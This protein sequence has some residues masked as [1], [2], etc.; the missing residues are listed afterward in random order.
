[1]VQLTTNDEDPI[2]TA[3]EAL[4]A[5]DVAAD[6]FPE[7]QRASAHVRCTVQALCRRAMLDAM[8]SDIRER[9]LV[10]E[11]RADLLDH[12]AHAARVAEQ[13]RRSSDAG[14]NTVNSATSYVNQLQ[15][16]IDQLCPCNTSVTADVRVAS[17]M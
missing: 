7:V 12:Q 8:R 16:N 6:A 17:Q 11:L 13:V 5:L 1:M 4:D 9:L 2:R 14:A 3:Y 10:H 15:H